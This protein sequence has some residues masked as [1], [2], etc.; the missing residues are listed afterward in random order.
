MT[1]HSKRSGIT[2]RFESKPVET[3]EHV[4]DPEIAP[5]APGK[6]WDSMTRATGRIDTDAA[7]EPGEYRNPLEKYQHG[8]DDQGIAQTLGERLYPRH[9]IEIDGTTGEK[10]DARIVRVE[11][12]EQVM[13]RPDIRLLSTRTFGH[14]D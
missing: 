5:D 11:Q 2:G 14:M 6:T 4:H 7:Y 13:E 9:P 3:G 10:L 8:P 12:P 1:R